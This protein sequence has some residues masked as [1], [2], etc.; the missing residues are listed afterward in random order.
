[1]QVHHAR[2]LVMTAVIYNIK[3]YDAREPE[4]EVQRTHCALYQLQTS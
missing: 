1:M 4:E 3:Y 2:V